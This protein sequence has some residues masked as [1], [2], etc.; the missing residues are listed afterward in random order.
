M[1]E[2][3]LSPSMQSLFCLTGPQVFKYPSASQTKHIGAIIF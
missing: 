3:F 2:S 1:A